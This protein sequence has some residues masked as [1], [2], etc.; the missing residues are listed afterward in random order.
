MS[1][2]KIEKFDGLEG[3]KAATIGSDLYRNHLSIET[4]GFDLSFGF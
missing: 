4:F 1:K 3:K 2:S